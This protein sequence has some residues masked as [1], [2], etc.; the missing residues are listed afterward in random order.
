MIRAISVFKALCLRFDDAGRP[1]RGDRLSDLFVIADELIMDLPALPRPS[2]QDLRSAFSTLPIQTIERDTSPTDA[3][4]MKLATV[5]YERKHTYSD[6]IWVQD[7]NGNRKYN[8]PQNPDH[9]W[10]THDISPADFECRIASREDQLLGYQH[11]A[12]LLQHHLEFPELVN[13]LESR[14]IIFPGIVIS[15]GGKRQSPMLLKDNGRIQIA[16]AILEGGYAVPSKVR[17]AFSHEE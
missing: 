7:Q 15:A 3:V 14:D 1:W 8:P 12:W 10:A 13:L 2:L 9:F 6:P 11:A 5:H 4:R 17:V 16:G